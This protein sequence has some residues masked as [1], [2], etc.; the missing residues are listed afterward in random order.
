MRDALLLEMDES[1]GTLQSFKIEVAD[2]PRDDR[3]A[4]GGCEEAATHYKRRNLE[5]MWHPM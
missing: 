2:P 3:E 1:H 4:Y 5:E